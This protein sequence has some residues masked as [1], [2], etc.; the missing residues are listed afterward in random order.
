MII[1]LRDVLK[2][3][4]R[5][6]CDCPCGSRLKSVCQRKCFPRQTTTKSWW[7]T[8][9]WKESHK[10]TYK[11]IQISRLL[12]VRGFVKKVTD[13]RQALK[14]K[15][16]KY[17]IKNFPLSSLSDQFPRAVYWAKVKLLVFYGV[18]WFPCFD[19]RGTVGSSCAEFWMLKN[20]FPACFL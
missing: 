19:H 11:Y 8:V 2:A 1:F 4:Y 17:S 18:V 3:R 12:K 13:S 14:I 6:S 20:N 9:E 15:F 5:L 10:S 16:Y 7:E